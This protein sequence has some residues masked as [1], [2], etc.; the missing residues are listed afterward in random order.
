MYA[1]IFFTERSKCDKFYIR[2][3]VLKDVLKKNKSCNKCESF[4]P[5]K[6]N[7]Q[8]PLPASP[9]NLKNRPIKESS[10]AK[11]KH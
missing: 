10:F 6:S 3:H 2:E 5:V 8:E 11:L 9:I 4:I 7:D 1:I